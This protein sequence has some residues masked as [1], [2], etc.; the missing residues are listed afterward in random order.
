MVTPR[1]G[2]TIVTHHN[3]CIPPTLNASCSITTPLSLFSTL[4]GA[5]VLPEKMRIGESMGRRGENG[6]SDDLVV[7]VRGVEEVQGV[8]VCC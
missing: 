1:D 4:K 8:A 3:H 6:G 2:L 7:K 5:R